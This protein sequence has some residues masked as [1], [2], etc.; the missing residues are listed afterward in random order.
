MI[1]EKNGKNQS[2]R[3][4]VQLF[5]FVLFDELGG[6]DTVFNLKMIQGAR[7][8]RKKKLA[9]STEGEGREK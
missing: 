1:F 4:S 5:V 6:T 7:R 3:R 2:V 9:L 8:M